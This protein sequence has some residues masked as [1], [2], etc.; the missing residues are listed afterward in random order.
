MLWEG[1]MWCM[2]LVKQ[3]TSTNRLTF[4]PTLTLMLVITSYLYLYICSYYSK[5]SKAF[6][7]QYRQ[8]LSLQIDHFTLQTVLHY[9]QSTDSNNAPLFVVSAC[10]YQHVSL[11]IAYVAV[12]SWFKWRWFRYGTQWATRTFYYGKLVSSVHL[13]LCL[14]MRRKREPHRLQTVRCGRAIPRR[15]AA[16]LPTH[17]QRPLRSAGIQNDVSFI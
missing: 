17:S 13:S 2:L 8:T 12:E 4:W 11:C 15:D 1:C 16:L 9:Y 7:T 14:C 3:D 10:L 6:F 5:A